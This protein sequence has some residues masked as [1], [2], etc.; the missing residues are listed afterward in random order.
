MALRKRGAVWWIDVVSPSGERI[1]RSAGTA[2]KTLAQE[3]H[4]RI[5]AELWRVDKLGAKP[6]RTWN[7]AVVRWL[8]ENRH[9]ATAS[10]DVTKLRWLDRYLRDH[11]LS[12]IDRT[13]ID[14]VTR[15]KLAQGCRNA[16]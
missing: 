5:K 9:K 3:L 7:E 2:V 14:Q 15:E 6:L 4:D 10:E 1:R 16:T 8:K 13:L 11:E 12:A